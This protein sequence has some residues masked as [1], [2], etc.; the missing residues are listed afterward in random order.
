MKFLV[1]KSLHSNPNFSL[2]ILSYSALLLLYVLGDLFY[3]YNF[4]GSSPQEVLA[5]LKGNE[6]EFIEALSLASVLE[7]IHISMFLSIMS[8]FSIMAIVLR[9][10]LKKTHKGLIISSSMGFLFLASLSFL[11]TY[12]ISDVFVYIFFYGTILWHFIAA[13]ALVIILYQ[14]GLKKA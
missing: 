5:T 3:M 10:A 9:L 13:Y 14:V 1:S 2:L 4:F 8:L 7:H 11:L 6:E 12:F